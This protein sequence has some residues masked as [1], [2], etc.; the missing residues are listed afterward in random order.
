VNGWTPDL[1]QA[2]IETSALVC[3]ESGRLCEQSA[4][5][6]GRNPSAALKP[7][8]ASMTA[9]ERRVS[10]YLAGRPDV[11]V[12]DSCLTWR[13]GLTRDVVADQA[14]ILATTTL[15]QRETGSCFECGVEGVVTR[16]LPYR[17]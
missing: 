10:E 15:Y 1:V 9:P 7:R 4:V 13:T 11:D 14:S 6:V 8:D 3:E 16:A 2:L 17:E 5:L 12:C